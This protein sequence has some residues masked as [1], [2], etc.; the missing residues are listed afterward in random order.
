MKFPPADFYIRA[1]PAILIVAAGQIVLRARLISLIRKFMGTSVISSIVMFSLGALMLA[2]VYTPIESLGFRVILIS[3][4]A[5][6]V[7]RSSGS[8]LLLIPV[9][10]FVFRRSD[11]NDVTLNS[12]LALAALALVIYFALAMTAKYVCSQNAS[13]ETEIATGDST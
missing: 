10:P 12:Y 4:L 1:L 11:M 9:E 13:T 7:I 2:L 8:V 3:C 6:W 5:V